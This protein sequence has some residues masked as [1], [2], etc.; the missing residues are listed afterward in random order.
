LGFA[1]SDGNAADVAAICR[2]LD[3]L[4]L[5]IELAASRA[6]LLAPG[7]MLA[8]LG[9]TLALAAPGAGRPSRQQTL[10]AA[11]GWSYDLL[12]PF[13]AAVLAR[14]GVFAGG[15]DL[16]ALAAVAGPGDGQ[17]GGADPLQLA[18]EL[19]DVSL[20]TVSEDADGEPRVGML[21]T[22]RQCALE[23]LAET[24]EAEDTRRRHAEHYAAFAEGAREQLVGPAQFATLDRLEADY[25]NLGGSLDLVTGIVSR[26][27]GP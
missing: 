13:S 23:R 19:M 5:A 12:A 16:D 6:R 4:P 7:A 24:G 26:R 18:E 27:S 8:R 17:P 20:V 25:D 3:G 14:M 1:L 11:I 21:E 15:C 2:R 9:S 22:I 10:R